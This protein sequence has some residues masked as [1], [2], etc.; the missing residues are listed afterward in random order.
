[1]QSQ[2][3]SSTPLPP[4][5]GLL[6]DTA[7]HSVHSHVAQ[8][9]PLSLA[10]YISWLPPTIHCDNWSGVGTLLRYIMSG[11]CVL[12]LYNSC[13]SL[14]IHQHNKLDPVSTALGLLLRT[15]HID[16]NVQAQP[17]S[18]FPWTTVKFGRLVAYF[19]SLAL[20]DFG[21]VTLNDNH[22]IKHHVSP[23]ASTTI[24]SSGFTRPERVQIC[25]S[26]FLGMDDTHFLLLLC[27]QSKVCL[28]LVMF[29]SLCH[30]CILSVVGCMI[31]GAL[32]IPFSN[33]DHGKC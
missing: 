30:P 27:R 4:R 14:I 25:S 21:V 8:A 26:R 2:S 16:I 24:A 17:I 32:S 5:N 10:C 15:F 1:M 12:R 13:K 20:S 6:T 33:N 28:Q 22:D 19:L 23:S 18:H 31:S 9:L 3:V 11:Y 7:S 29:F